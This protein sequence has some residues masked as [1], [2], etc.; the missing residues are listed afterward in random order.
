MATTPVFDQPRKNWFQRHMGLT[1]AGGCGIL[2]AAAATLVLLIVAFVFGLLKNSDATKLAVERA[3][4]NATVVAHIGKPLELGW[5][6][7][8][9]INVS[10]P[11]GH[12]ELSIP[13]HGNKGKGTIYVVA[14]KNAGLWTFSTLQVAFAD[15]EPRVDLQPPATEPVQ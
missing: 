12:A 6:I 14:D 8:G 11:S 15:G 1:I 5:I 9:N 13:V 10:G 7:S 3:Q 4:S 2:L